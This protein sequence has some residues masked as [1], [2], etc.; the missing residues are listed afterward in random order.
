[1]YFPFYVKLFLSFSLS[2]H[3]SLLIGFC[4]SWSC[5]SPVHSFSSHCFSPF[6]FLVISILICISCNF[7]SHSIIFPVSSPSVCSSSPL[8]LFS[9][10]LLVMFSFLKLLTSIPPPKLFL[11]SFIVVSF[12]STHLRTPFHLGSLSLLSLFSP[13][14]SPKPPSHHLLN[15]HLVVFLSLY[16][17]PFSLHLFSYIT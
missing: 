12:L 9:F 15:P 17:V 11:L 6:Y 8:Y 10:L 1:M 4:T 16:C 7:T 2:C 14:F 13:L 3:L 5:T